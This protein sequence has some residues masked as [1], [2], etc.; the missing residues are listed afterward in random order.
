[1]TVWSLVLLTAGGG[2]VFHG[3]G[4][5]SWRSEAECREIQARIDQ[6]RLTLRVKKSL[7]EETTAKRSGAEM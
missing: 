6:R 5:W 2:V 4:D 1:M 7:I 3:P